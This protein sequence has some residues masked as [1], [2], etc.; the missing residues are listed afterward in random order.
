MPPLFSG[1]DNVRLLGRGLRN[2]VLAGISARF[3]RYRMVAESIKF[4]RQRPVTRPG[5]RMLPVFQAAFA[6]R[7]QPFG[8]IALTEGRENRGRPV[9]ALFLSRAPGPD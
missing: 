1:S 3:S 2:P 7:F 8:A 5:C 4:S 9:T 6:F